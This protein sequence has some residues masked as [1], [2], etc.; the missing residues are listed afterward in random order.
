MSQPLPSGTSQSVFLNNNVAF[1][2][3]L[4]EKG[5]STF[6]QLVNKFILKKHW[7]FDFDPG[8]D[9]FLIRTLV[10]ATCIEVTWGIKDKFISSY[11]F[12]KVELDALRLREAK[13]HG[14]VLL[15]EGDID[16]RWK[17]IK[18]GEAVADSPKNIGLYDWSKALIVGAKRGNTL[19]DFFSGYYKT[20][21]IEA[22]KVLQMDTDDD[23]LPFIVKQFF[24]QPDE[25]KRK[26]PELYEYTKMLLNLDLIEAREFDFIYSEKM[27]SDK[28]MKSRNR[29]FIFGVQKEMRQYGVSTS[30][31]YS[32]LI[33]VPITFIVF[34]I[35]GRQTYFSWMFFGIYSGLAGIGAGAIYHF[36]YK[37]RG[38]SLKS[39][40]ALIGL[41]L[42]PGIY[43]FMITLNSNIKIK[44]NVHNIHLEQAY[45]LYQHLPWPS[46]N[47]L[48]FTRLTI[49][50]EDRKT[51]KSES[52]NHTARGEIAHYVKELGITDDVEVHTRTGI[53]GSEVYESFEVTMYYK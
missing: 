39:M 30:I 48:R 47:N 52:Q 15:L 3:N 29:A 31:I 34:G 5:K 13:G 12:V 45:D 53:F 37:Q 51:G 26:Y 20:W 6:L 25:L 18:A 1:Y 36:Y 9:A 14:K 38:L 27:R 40:A 7:E 16:A 44:Q 28:K 2:R 46:F 19:D 24:A 22:Q 43:S 33:I 10:A 8:N 21:L 49:N 35:M 4:S 11:K 17:K 23:C 41:G 32:I 50:R 42:L